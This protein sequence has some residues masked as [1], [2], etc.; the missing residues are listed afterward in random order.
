MGEKV[1]ELN[2][3]LRGWANYFRLGPVSPAYRLIDQQACARLR[4]WLCTKHKVRGAGET[5][6]PDKYLYQQLGLVRLSSRTR[7]FSWAKA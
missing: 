1:G 3:K 6:Y 7:S 5:Q 4:Q 2:R